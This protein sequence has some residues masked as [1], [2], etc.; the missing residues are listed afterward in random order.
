MHTR[1]WRLI[2]GEYYE[3]LPCELVQGRGNTTARLLTQAQWLI[4]RKSDGRYLAVGGE[5]WLQTLKRDPKLHRACEQFYFNE[6][7]FSP[8]TSLHNVR[9]ILDQLQISP[10]Y[11]TEHQLVLIPE[12][13]QLAFAGFDRYQ[14]P[15]WMQAEAAIAW[16]KMQ[17]AAM[18][19]E[20]LL[21][22]ISGYR[23]HAYQHGIFK[24]KLARGQT[25][26]EILKVNA[27]PG[28][29]EHHSGCAIDIGTPNEPPAEE[30]F[31]NTMTFAWLMKHA[32]D[33]GFRLSYPRDNPHNIN[34]E[35][36]HWYFVGVT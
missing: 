25:V 30:S 10:D 19:N 23:G 34:Y 7:M 21:E 22:A 8:E 13:S 18:V 11:G 14:R 3:A 36:W 12:P 33:F 17:K 24:R 27:A 5:D 20:V 4:R 31:E 15:L 1:Q 35:P 9:N 32:P 28:Y 2:N 16:K 29:S 26:Q 6:N